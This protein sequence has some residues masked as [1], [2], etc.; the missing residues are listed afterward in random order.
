M[1][2]KISNFYG[3]HWKYVTSWSNKQLWGSELTVKSAASVCKNSSTNSEVFAEF[4]FSGEPL[5]PDGVAIPCGNIAKHWFTDW[6]ELFDEDGKQIF[7]DETDI[8][9]K[10]DNN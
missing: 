6:Y 7:I 5:D 10:V 8:A 9:R 1:Y 2:Q 3:S 4:S